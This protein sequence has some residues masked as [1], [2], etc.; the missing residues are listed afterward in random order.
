MGHIANLI[1][2]SS[3][4]VVASVYLPP[5]TS[6][7]NKITS[8]T[9]TSELSS[10]NDL[11]FMTETHVWRMHQSSKNKSPLN[12]QHKL[13]DLQ[14][15]S[16]EAQK[17]D[18]TVPSSPSPSS[19]HS[20]LLSSDKVRPASTLSSTLRMKLKEP[21]LNRRRKI[22]V[23]EIGPM[24][25][26]QELA[27]DSRKYSQLSNLHVC[28]NLSHEATIP[29][30]PPIHE[31][32]HSVPVSK[33][34]QKLGESAVTLLSGPVPDEKAEIADLQTSDTE[35]QEEFMETFRESVPL[36]ITLDK[37]PLPQPTVTT[38]INNTEQ[39]NSTQQQSS[40]TLKKQKSPKVV[41]PINSQPPEVPPK[42]LKAHQES[43]SSAPKSLPFIP[44]SSWSSAFSATFSVSTPT[45][46]PSSEGRSSP[47]PWSFGRSSPKTWS[48]GGRSSPKS[49][50]TSS[51]S[52]LRL[53]SQKSET[54]LI[55]EASKMSSKRGHGRH[56]SEDNTGLKS[57]DRG[58]SKQRSN[59]SI[60]SKEEQKMNSP[61][62]ISSS[63]FDERN[64][65]L[66]NSAC[67]LPEP[68]CFLSLPTGHPPGSAS[69]NFNPTE[70]TY[71]Q[72][73]AL[74][75]AFRFEVLPS[76][77]VAS[78]SRE[79]RALDERC[80]Y[81]RKTHLSLRNDRQSQHARMFSNLRNPR[82]GR[83]SCDVLS[84]FE[85]NLCE[86]DRCIDACVSKF[87]LAENRR[88]RVRQKLLEHVAAAAI[89]DIQ[90]SK[91]NNLQSNKHA[92][93][94]ATGENTPPRSPQH[95]PELTEL[96]LN[97]IPLYLEPFISSIPDPLLLQT[98]RKCESLPESPNEKSSEESE[99]NFL[100]QDSN[101]A[102][103][104]QPQQDAYF[105]TD[106][107]VFDLMDCVEEEM[108]RMGM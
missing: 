37:S 2:D 10:A 27:M 48:I 4:G 81:L 101:L 17:S 83:S 74:S 51:T 44:I 96:E 93:P 57:D 52:S 21:I 66:T 42:Q 39:T 99:K 13:E 106:K 41:S 29:G 105:Y 45:I 18:E 40:C 94:D 31:R 60:I 79:L 69:D 70:L 71:L 89:V 58:R 67:S 61:D 77:D 102:S 19:F 11:E 1:L 6:S 76:R 14:V 78:L 73:Q 68:Q 91:D 36:K 25:T 23:Q 87:E 95:G 24:T 64:S 103:L 5:P 55:S 16:N 65:D 49:S 100:N 46:S 15:I 86:L 90:S 82:V 80:E 12:Q 34:R 98:P 26:V 97:G 20:K 88:M 22:S 53:H 3:V 50:P 7:P 8:F 62:P 56:S 9:Q 32:S 54:S 108:E 85:G 47:K 35:N 84:K 30:R 72:N 75:Q 107:D 104:A 59:L 33:S 63:P 92:S 38:P 28:V 43:P